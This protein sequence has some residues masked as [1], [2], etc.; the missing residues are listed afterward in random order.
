MSL[1]LLVVDPSHLPSHD[2]WDAV[3]C[4]A[5][6]ADNSV[7]L[8][9]PSRV[10]STSCKVGDPASAAKAGKNRCT[11]AGCIITQVSLVREHLSV[12][13]IRTNAAATANPS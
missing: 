13:R 12:H 9:S 1:Q 7:C 4:F 11:T 2:G 8:I 3:V 6:L 5:T 10:V